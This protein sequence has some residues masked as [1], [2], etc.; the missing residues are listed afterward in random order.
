MR[1]SED[2]AGFIALHIVNAQMD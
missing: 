1:L 2:E